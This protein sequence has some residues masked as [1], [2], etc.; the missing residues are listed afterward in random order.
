MKKSYKFKKRRIDGEYHFVSSKFDV[1]S[2]SNGKSYNEI[3][4]IEA[5]RKEVDKPLLLI[6]GE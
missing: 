3:E 5:S 6:R 2:S 4:A 1:K